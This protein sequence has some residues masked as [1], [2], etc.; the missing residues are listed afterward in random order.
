MP[1][2]RTTAPAAQAA[3][4][5]SDDDAVRTMSDEAFAAMCAEMRTRFT[6][7][8]LGEC[9][10]ELLEPVIAEVAEA[11]LP[12]LLTARQAARQLGLSTTAVYQMMY[13]GDLASIA[14]PTG[15]PHRTL[16][17]VE[18]AEVSAFIERNRV[19]TAGTPGYI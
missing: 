12:R 6:K 15:N 19:A 16:R 7:A 3:A 10:A 11:L 18:Q 2:P 4:Q 9:L 17:R 8:R 13:K 14:I 5:P 1:V